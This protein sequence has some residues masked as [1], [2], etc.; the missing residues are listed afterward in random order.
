[1]I[2]IVGLGNPG[3]RFKKTRHNLGFLVLDKLQ[4]EKAF[5]N[6]K[7]NKK[8]NCFYSKRVIASQQI[9]LV[10]P[11]T[12][13]NNSGK[14]V[15]YVQKKHNLSSKNI[16]VVHDDID[17]PL[18]KIRIFFGRGAAGHK[19]VESIIKELKSKNFVRFRIGICP[20]TGKPKNIE[21]FVLQKFDQKEEKIVKKV[22]KKTIEAIEFSLKTSLEKAMSKYNI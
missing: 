13:M 14:V 18:G 20:K 2:L 11:L 6:W 19:G 12:Y 5:P 15:K 4:Q 8:A 16:L 17:I 10:K 1:M 9:E 22:I 7:K 3:E 21:K